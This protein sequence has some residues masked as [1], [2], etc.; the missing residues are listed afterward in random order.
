MEGVGNG[1]GLA[2]DGGVTMAGVTSPSRVC[3]TV[4][5]EQSTESKEYHVI[6][7]TESK[8]HFTVHET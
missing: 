2:M 3:V 6:S 1:W 4:S 8:E 5:R 7:T